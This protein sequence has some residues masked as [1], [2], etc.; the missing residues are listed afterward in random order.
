MRTL[1]AI[2]ARNAALLVETGLWNT[3]G[4]TRIPRYICG[5]GFGL[6]LVVAGACRDTPA[7]ETSAP[8]DTGDCEG[9]ENCFCKDDSECAPGLVCA[10]RLCTP[11]GEGE[12][13]STNVGSDTT[14]GTG[15]EPGSSSESSG[16]STG[17]SETEGPACLVDQGVI[18]G[19]CDD[20]DRPYCSADG[21][22]V[23]CVGLGGCDSVGA[24]TPVCNTSSG[25]CVQCT[26]SDIGACGGTTPVC[27]DLNACVGCDEHEQCASGACNFASGA[28]FEEVLHV[29]RGADCGAGDGSIEA[30]FCEIQDA[31]SAAGVGGP[32]VVKVKSSPSAF[33]KQI[34][35]SAGRSI[36]IVRDG[37]GMVTLTVP[38]LDPV[39]VNDGAE[40]FLYNLRITGGSISKGLLCLS[41]SVWLDRIQIDKREGHAI[42]ASGCSLTI[43]RSKIYDNNA[44]G[45]KASDGTTRIENSFIVQNGNTFA[46][47][48][49]ITLT[50][51]ADLD[52]VYST[53]ADNDAKNGMGDSLH[54]TGLGAVSLRNA[55]VFGANPTT[56]VICPGAD[57]RDSVVDATS[58]MG[59][60]VVHEPELD[61]AW[62]I[63]P[64]SGNFAIKPE[65]PFKGVAKWRAEDPRVDFDGDP[66]P[67]ED[68]DVDYTGADRPN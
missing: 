56:S 42:D 33:T 61:P 41:A 54:C 12:S 11:E 20:P 21:E 63:A 51:G 36:A 57:T 58:L 49:G 68:G 14:T 64:A 15:S 3:A 8:D 25:L 32:T 19:A 24:V 27:N 13:S 1:G 43:R 5:L 7:D 4:V 9:R 39:V 50:N 59:S 48:S 45:V 16:D 46:E 37:S 10:S 60:G 26:A 53:I 22:C 67:G 23:D 2:S 65:T 44:G 6:G 66:R 29:D 18:N 31:V 30:P 28:C 62:F 38:D 52:V 40:A 55:I 47:V 35:V 34:Q 17:P